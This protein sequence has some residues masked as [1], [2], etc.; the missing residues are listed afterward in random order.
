[1]SCIHLPQTSEG[2]FREEDISGLILLVTL[3]PL[4]TAQEAHEQ[5]AGVAE[6]SNLDHDSMLGMH[7][8]MPED[9]AFLRHTPARA[10]HGS[11]ASVPGHEWRFMRG[12]WKPMAQAAPVHS[13][14]RVGRAPWAESATSGMNTPGNLA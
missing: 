1:M 12:G 6:N 10:L 7:M 5:P 11:H 8:D 3:S 2:S 9:S 14:Y 13:A 4:S